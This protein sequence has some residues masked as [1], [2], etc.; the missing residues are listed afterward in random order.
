M[1]DIDM[2]ILLDIADDDLK[3]LIFIDEGF[4]YPTQIHQY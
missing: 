2:Y 4:K 1:I 3:H